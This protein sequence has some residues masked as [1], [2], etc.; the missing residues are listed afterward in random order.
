MEFKDKQ[1]DDSW[2]NQ[3]GIYGYIDTEMNEVV[4]IGQTTVSFKE[5]DKQHRMGNPETLCERK[6]Q[7]Y[8]QKYKM[9]PIESFKSRSVT[10]EFLNPIEEENI[11]KFNT[12]RDENP[13][14]LNLTSGGD[15]F[16]SSNISNKKKSLSHN[17]TGF[18][19]VSKARSDKYS[20][21][22]YFIYFYQEDGK[23]KVITS[24]DIQ[25]LEI[26]VKQKN[27]PWEKLPGEY[28]SIPPYKKEESKNKIFFDS[29]S[30]ISINS[31]YI[32]KH[33]CSKCKRGFIFTYCYNDKNKERKTISS[34]DLEK[35]EKKVKAKKLPWRGIPQYEEIEKYIPYE[36]NITGYY[37]VSKIKRK[38]TKQGFTFRYTY[39]QN[40][41]QKM[42]DNVDIKKLE[43]EVKKRGLVWRK[44]QQ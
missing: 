27:L 13:Y 11:K 6:I 2:K 41:K 29:K 43:Q 32:Y 35:L 14:G 39:K 17:T 7:K 38:R 36:K 3:C 26:K 30:H 44:I 22:Y 31:A 37:R 9:I 33:K 23:Q 16:T 1:E 21:G 34:V 28:D 5:R 42:I 18:R 4:Y 8:P 10:N 20:Q 12:F 15:A 19:W 40:G 24:V 25:K